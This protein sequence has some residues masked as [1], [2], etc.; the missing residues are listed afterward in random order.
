MV[1]ICAVGAELDGTFKRALPIKGR[2]LSI[3][4]F[5]QELLETLTVA[6]RNFSP[7]WRG[8]PYTSK[9]K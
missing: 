5:E 4:A 8:V 6:A 7:G 3:I 9:N 1:E 2:Q